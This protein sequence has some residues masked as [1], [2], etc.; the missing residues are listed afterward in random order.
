M[1]ARFFAQQQPVKIV[2]TDKFYYVFICL[3]GEEKSEY[4][5]STSDE[6]EEKVLEKYIE[7]DYTELVINKADPEYDIEEIKK[8]PE[9]YIDIDD[10][11]NVLKRNKISNSKKILKNY[12]ESHP[13]FSKAKYDDGRYYTVTEE[14]QRQLTSKMAMYNIYAQQSLPYG[15]LKWN[16]TGSVC[17]EWTIEELTQLSMEIDSYVTPLVSKQQSY[18]YA[19]RNANTEE[20]VNSIDFNL[21]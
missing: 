15:L 8:N 3:N 17:E 13:L 19:V 16:D 1:K 11:L 12:L 20:E 14:K 7:Y 9:Y 2:E 18:E 5:S 10:P 6:T 21:E 4:Y